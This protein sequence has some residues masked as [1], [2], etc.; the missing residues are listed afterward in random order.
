MDHLSE[1]AAAKVDAKEGEK[2]AEGE[3]GREGTEEDLLIQSKEEGGLLKAQGTEEVYL[4]LFMEATKSGA[5]LSPASP[6][7][8]ALSATPETSWA[9]MP[10]ASGGGRNSYS[11]SRL[12]RALQ[13][14]VRR[15]FASR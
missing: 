2:G 13:G 6:T 14:I 3:E 8:A 15:F 9:G 11:G 1:A 4:S 5:P 12:R 7:S 10:S